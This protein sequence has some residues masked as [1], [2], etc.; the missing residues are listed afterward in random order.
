VSLKKFFLKNKVTYKLYLYYN[1]YIRHKCYINRK[2]YSQWGEDNY[3]QSFFKKNVQG[4]Y[5]DIGCFHPFMYSNTCLLHK[6]GWNGINIDINQTSIDLFKLSRPKDINICA[7]ISDQKKES[8]L[9]FDDSFSP[10]NTINEKFYEN[11]KNV[12]FK[13]KK[14]FK[15]QTILME[16]IF[17]KYKN[18]TNFDFIN[19]DAEGFDFKILKQIDLEKFKVKLLAIETHNV[20]GTKTKDFDSIDSYLKGKNFFIFKR[21]GPTTLFSIKGIKST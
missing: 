14:I 15:V 11:L 19:I 4:T 7:A 3:I 17:N 13:D 1:L 8:T 12:F 6:K 21:V 5:L 10:V 2:Q 9:Y 18:K 20:D 16:E